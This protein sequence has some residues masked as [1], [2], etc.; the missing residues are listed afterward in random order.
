MG[1]LGVYLMTPS[2]ISYRGVL[3]HIETG[4]PL[5]GVGV[6]LIGT[7]CTTQTD[8]LGIFDFAGCTDPG[9]SRVENPRI[10]ILPSARRPGGE[11]DWDCRDIRLNP[12]PQMTEVRLDPD[13]PRRCSKRGGDSYATS[14]VTSEP[15][16]APPPSASA[17]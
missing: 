6:L 8:A 9:V 11:G 17:R 2:K 15:Y 5:K 7:S 3:R 16:I 13:G 14:V 4:Q 10:S 1:S 12:L